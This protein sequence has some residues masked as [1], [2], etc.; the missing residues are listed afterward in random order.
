MTAELLRRYIVEFMMTQNVIRK[1]P[2]GTGKLVIRKLVT[3]E[4]PASAFSP[5]DDVDTEL[6]SDG[7][8]K[9][10]GLETWKPD[11]DREQVTK[12]HKRRKHRRLA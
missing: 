7:S 3:Y 1:D 5:G 10:D 2:E 9:V 11:F 6:R 8:V 12:R 4:K